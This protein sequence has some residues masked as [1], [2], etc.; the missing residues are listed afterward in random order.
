MTTSNPYAAPKAAVADSVNAVQGSFV[1]GGRGVS[2]G[3]GWS[4]IT[5]GWNLFKRQPGVWIGTILV[6]LLIM[7]AL[8]FIPV[9]GS[10]VASLL[11]PVFSAGLVYGSRQLDEGRELELGHLFAGFRERFGP[12]MAVGGLYLASWV[13]IALIAALFTGASVMVLLGG[14]ADAEASGPAAVTTILLAA[15]V[16]LALMVPVFM[17][18][19]FAPQLVLF[20]N[21]G[22]LEAMRESF[23]ACLK[24][25]A[26]FLIYGLIALVLSILAAIPL[27]LGFVALGPVI[28][29]SLYTSY[30]DVFFR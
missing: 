26:P 11:G 23:F 20:H 4:W 13:V 6:L 15:L 1:P 3:H 19:W 14:P 27:M 18:L 8:G 10:L 5:E 22:A 12:L 9:A 21:R 17:A 25:I 24:N 2:A 28:A 29:A 16:V 30:R 7:L